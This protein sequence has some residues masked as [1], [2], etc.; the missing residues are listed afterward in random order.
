VHRAI[1]QKTKQITLIGRGSVLDIG[2]PRCGGE[3]RHH[4]DAVFF[5]RDE[6]KRVSA[7]APAIRVHDGRE[8]S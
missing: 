7:L 1:L 2:C 6:E 5:Y 4:T 3:Y 8:C